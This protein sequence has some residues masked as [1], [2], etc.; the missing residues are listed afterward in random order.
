MPVFPL[1]RTDKLTVR[2][3]PDET[4]VY[5]HQRHK[6]HCLNATAALVWQ[7]CDGRTSA[8]ALAGLVA[9]RLGVG[10]AVEVVGLALEQ[11]GRRHLLPLTLVQVAAFARRKIPHVLERLLRRRSRLSLPFTLHRH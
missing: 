5:D 1:A 11:L 7:H 3:L 9:E 6:A 8:D 2:A 10:Q 4:L